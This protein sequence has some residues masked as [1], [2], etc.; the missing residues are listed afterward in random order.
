M[1]HNYLTSSFISGLQRNPKRKLTEEQ[2]NEI[3]SIVDDKIHE[4]TKTIKNANFDI[5]PKV[6]KGKNISCEHCKFKDICYK[7]YRDSI[8]ISQ[9]EG[10]ENEQ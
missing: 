5:N 9:E 7:T 4:A 6:V 10:D 8:I 1:D 2:Y 3:F